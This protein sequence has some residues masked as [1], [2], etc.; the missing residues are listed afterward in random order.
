MR[1]GVVGIGQIAQMV[2]P[3]LLKDECAELVAVAD[4]NLGLSALYGVVKVTKEDRK[5]LLELDKTII[6]KLKYCPIFEPAYTAGEVNETCSDTS[7][8]SEIVSIMRESWFL[9]LRNVTRSSQ[10]IITLVLRQSC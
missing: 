9:Y 2:Y 4:V 10:C 7:Y 5:E 8:D 1:V 3:Y 6:R